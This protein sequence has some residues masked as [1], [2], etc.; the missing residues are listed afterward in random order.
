ML[1]FWAHAVPE[2]SSEQLPPQVAQH[3]SASIQGPDGE[4]GYPK[5]HLGCPTGHQGEGKPGEGL[6]MDK[7]SQMFSRQSNCVYMFGLFNENES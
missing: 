3:H 7:M 5:E 4:A 6:L 1:Y 2:S